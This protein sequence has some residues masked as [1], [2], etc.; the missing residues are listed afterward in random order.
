MLSA[1]SIVTNVAAS[2]QWSQ[3]ASTMILTRWC[4]LFCLRS[5]AFPYDERSQNVILNKGMPIIWKV[6]NGEM[7]LVY[8]TQNL[9]LLN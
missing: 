5:F 2:E 1:G 3:P 9:K 4:P 8:N 6:N 7:G